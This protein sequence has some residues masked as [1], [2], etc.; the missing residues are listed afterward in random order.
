V[1]H[2]GKN[3]G[4]PWTGGTC[5]LTSEIKYRRAPTIMKNIQACSM[6]L[7][8]DKVK[9]DSYL[10]T[11]IIVSIKVI[12]VLVA[13]FSLLQNLNIK[14]RTKEKRSKK[15]I[16]LCTSFNVGLPTYCTKA[17]VILHESLSLAVVN[18]E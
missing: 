9:V 17:T 10:L 8:T 18:C 2:H 4:S 6:H 1:Q 3:S 13:G 7:V 12:L 11:K 14:L 16:L 5:R 15:G